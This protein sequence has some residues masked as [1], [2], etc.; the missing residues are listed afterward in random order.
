MV[1]IILRGQV[2]KCNLSFSRALGGP[3]GS[4]QRGAV[5]HLIWPFCVC[6]DMAHTKYRELHF[7]KIITS[8]IGMGLVT[9]HWWQVCL[10]N[11]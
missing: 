5:G 2:P 6:A 4:S 9:L 8:W 11:M 10:S 3:T 1:N 7:L